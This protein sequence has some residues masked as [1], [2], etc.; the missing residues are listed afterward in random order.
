MNVIKKYWEL[1]K[2]NFNRCWQQSGQSLTRPQHYVSNCV[3]NDYCKRHWDT[4]GPKY[5]LEIKHASSSAD[6]QYTGNQMNNLHEIRIKGANW[7]IIGLLN[8]N[9]LQNK[10]EMLKELIKDKIG[11]F[12]IFEIKLD[13]SFS[14]G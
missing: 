13:S 2:K 9:S 8:I 4:A 6:F 12:L 14:S 7:L 1:R 3:R 5:L 11:I 10:F